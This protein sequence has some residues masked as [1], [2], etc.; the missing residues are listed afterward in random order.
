M[1][2]REMAASGMDA[3][4]AGEQQLPSGIAEDLGGLPVS[5]KF[6]AELGEFDLGTADLETGPQGLLV[7]ISPRRSPLPELAALAE[8]IGAD[9]ACLRLEPFWQPLEAPDLSALSALLGG[10]LTGE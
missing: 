5:E 1:V 3:E 4:S 8:R 9:I 6:A 2:R 7:Q 10:F